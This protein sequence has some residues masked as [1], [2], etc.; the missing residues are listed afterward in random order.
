MIGI[1]IAGKDAALPMLELIVVFFIGLLWN[2]SRSRPVLSAPEK[3][4]SDLRMLGHVF[5]LIAA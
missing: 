5:F 3:K 2:W 4:G 1:S